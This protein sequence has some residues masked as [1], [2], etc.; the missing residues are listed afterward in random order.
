MTDTPLFTKV[1]GS[2]VDGGGVTKK[3]TLKPA[4]HL[5]PLNMEAVDLEI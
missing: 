3:Q 5:P 2:F 1:E 4:A